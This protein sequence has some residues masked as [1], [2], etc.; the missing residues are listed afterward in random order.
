MCGMFIIDVA[1]VGGNFKEISILMHLGL[2]KN[3]LNKFKIFF[4]LTMLLLLAS[5]VASSFDYFLGIR[6]ILLP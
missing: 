2:W 5:F 1:I 3:N 6:G 4:L